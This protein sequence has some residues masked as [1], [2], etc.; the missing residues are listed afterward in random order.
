MPRFEIGHER[1]WCASRH[2]DRALYSNCATANSLRCVTANCPFCGNVKRP[3]CGTENH[4]H[5]PI[6]TTKRYENASGLHC[7]KT[8]D[9]RRGSMRTA[10]SCCAIYGCYSKP[11]GGENRYHYP[12]VNLTGCVYSQIDSH[13]AQTASVCAHFHR[14]S[15]LVMTAQSPA[16]QA[17]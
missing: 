10:H 5:C 3:N 9:S 7:A 4:S 1:C 8:S 6:S 14:D 16:T 11:S 17:C 15:G 2:F 13:H 12:G